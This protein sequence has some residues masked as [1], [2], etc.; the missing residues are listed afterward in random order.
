VLP[1]LT[2]IARVELRD[3]SEAALATV[4]IPGGRLAI[5]DGVDLAA[6]E[7]RR[8][9][10]RAKLESEIERVEAKLANPAFVANAPAAVVA[11]EREKLARLQAELDSL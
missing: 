9:R 11:A 2:R 6:Q 5:L 7:V 3:G 1:L 8:G 4:A 10:E